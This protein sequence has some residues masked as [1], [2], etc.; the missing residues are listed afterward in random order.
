MLVGHTAWPTS[1]MV[2]TGPTGS[3]DIQW[4]T[5]HRW[6][7]FTTCSLLPTRAWQGLSLYLLH[8]HTHAH[9]R[10]HACVDTP[11][12]MHAHASAHTQEDARRRAARDKAE[13]DK[14]KAASHVHAQHAAP[15]TD[16]RLRRETP[17][18]ATLRFKNDLP[19]VRGG[20]C[21]DLAQ[22]SASPATCA[23]V[24][25]VLERYM[26]SRTASQPAAD[27]IRRKANRL[28]QKLTLPPTMF[29]SN[30]LLQVPSDPKL[31]NSNTPPVGAI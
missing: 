8:A 17:F 18:I 25:H 22:A 3:C 23:Q 5:C 7:V 9:M 11:I 14:A 28:T 27:A 31:V 12:C 4:S 30:T 1:S 24:L 21:A 6:H 20:W 29:N 19:E 15:A 26:C 10:T 16:N 2:R 13:R